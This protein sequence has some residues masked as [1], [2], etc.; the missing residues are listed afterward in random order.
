M[1]KRLSLKGHDD[2]NPKCFSKNNIKKCIQREWTRRH[3]AQMAN[4]L[5]PY[6]LISHLPIEHL[7]LQPLPINKTRE[8]LG[9]LCDLLTGHC[10]LQLFQYRAKLTFSPVCTC[11]EDEE[12]VLHFLYHCKDYKVVRTRTSPDVNNW[13]TVIEYISLTKRL[14]P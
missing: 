1:H 12:T 8:E 4:A 6:G 13:Q 14:S 9:T 3:K 10:A 11:L 2:I 5:C 7:T